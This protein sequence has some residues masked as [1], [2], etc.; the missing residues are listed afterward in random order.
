MLLRLLLLSALSLACTSGAFAAEPAMGALRPMAGRALPALEKLPGREAAQLAAALKKHAG[1]PVIVNFWASWCEPCRQ[2]MPALQALAQRQ[3]DLTVI[4]VAVN[5]RKDDSADF[6][7]EKDITLTALPDRE[8]T[9]S[10]AWGA[11][12]LPTTL[13]LDRHHHPR[14]RATGPVDWEGKAAA[15]VIER[16]LLPGR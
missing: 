16:L 11:R 10:Q 5:D 12:V 9:I 4:L 8:Q 13:L 14:Y 15:K 2:E 7:W 1:R 6:L 3:K